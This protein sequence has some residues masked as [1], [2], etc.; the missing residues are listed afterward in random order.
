MS[1]GGVEW[2]LEVE[3]GRHVIPPGGRLRGVLRLTATRDIG[4]R[5]VKASLVGV[6]HYAFDVTQRDSRN[7]S[8]TDRRWE[9]QEVFRQELELMGSTSIAAGETR[10]LP[11]ELALPPDAPPSLETSVLRMRWLSRAWIDVGGGLDPSAEQAILVPMTP[12]AVRAADPAALAER[13]DSGGSFAIAVEPRPLITGAPFSGIVDMQ[14]GL[15]LGKT[16]VEVKLKAASNYSDGGLD[17][18]VTLPGGLRL[19]S[20]ARRAAVETRTVWQGSLTE[21]GSKDGGHRYAFQGQLPAE[22]IATVSLPHG[23]VTA[24]IDVIVDRRLRPDEHFTRPVA[25]VSG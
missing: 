22:P 18:G 15:D 20:N 16:R 12:D 10:S 9:S 13:S 4:A 11:F 6:E 23:S 25:I 7:Q 24:T 21:A 14:E 17:L 19:D 3:G 1:G 8:R 2:V 5:A